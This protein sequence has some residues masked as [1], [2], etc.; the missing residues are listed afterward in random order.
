MLVIWN[1]GASAIAPENTLKSFQKA[2]ELKADYIEFDIH[3]T[4]DDK[5]VIIHDAN[6]IN[7]TGFSGDIRGMKLSDIKKLDA[8][9]GEK[10]PTLEELIKLAKNKIKLQVE[11]KAP[12]LEN[13]LV[14]LLR[15]NDLIESS[16]VSSFDIKELLKI[17]KIEPR[18]KL[19]YLIPMVLTKDRMV[20]RYVQKAIDNRF[21]AIHPYYQVVDQE[22][23]DF[24]SGWFPEIYK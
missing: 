4:L 3:R 17:N 14:D 19:G 24:A 8:G 2:I 7:T 11:V 12:G 13:Q 21:F 15:E 10:I 9:E 1:K 22:F 23:V 5:I 18:L 20:K 16:I 6:T